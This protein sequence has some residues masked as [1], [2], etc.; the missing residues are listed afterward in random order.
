MVIR[1]KFLIIGLL[2]IP[3]ISHA[4]I[5]KFQKIPFFQNI[6][7]IQVACGDYHSLCLSKHGHVFTWGFEFHL[8][9]SLHKKLGTSE[10]VGKPGLITA[11]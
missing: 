9:G 2:G 8:G 4:C 3:D 10:A 1:Y 6:P 11:L 7:I 5:I